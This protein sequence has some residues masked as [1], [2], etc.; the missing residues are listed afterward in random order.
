PVRSYT[1]LNRDTQEYVRFVNPGDL[2]AADQTCGESGCHREI[3]YNVKNSLMTHGA[4]LWGAALYNN[5][6]Y[7]L[8]NAAFGEAYDARGIAR[9]LFTIPSP[10]PEETRLKGVLPMLLPLPQFENTQPGNTLRVFERGDDRLSN[11]G[12]GTLTRTDPVFQGLQRTRLLDPLLY[13]LGTNDQP[14]DFRS[15]GCTACHVVYANDRDPAHSGLYARYGH[16]GQSATADPT[17]PKNE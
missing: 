8:K 5:G 13:F 14:G 4:F 3:V 17:I 6:S 15:S 7:P 16:L 10:A 12:F 11:R 2:R 9:K 1:L